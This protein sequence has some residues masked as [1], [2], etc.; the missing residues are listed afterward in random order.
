ML[1]PTYKS[2]QKLAARFRWGTLDKGFTG[3]DTIGEVEDY[4][5]DTKVPILGDYNADNIV[6]AADHTLWKSTLG[7]T[8]DL[9]ADGNKN[10]VI[11]T[12]DYSIWRDRLGQTSGGGAAAVVISDS[13]ASEAMLS[14][15]PVAESAPSAGAAAFQTLTLAVYDE[16]PATEL[17]NTSPVS[18][19]ATIVVSTIDSTSTSELVVIELLELQHSTSVGHAVDALAATGPSAGGAASVDLALLALVAGDVRS[20]TQNDDDPSADL[21]WLN[22]DGDQDAELD[23]ALAAAF[24]DEVDWRGVL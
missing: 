14:A 7:S 12:G 13:P 5:F 2:G 20:R 10:G 16:G 24:E 21:Q 3:H 18:A 1:L 15:P 6:D 8:T 19:S 22:E 11:D 23:L 17:G 4:R 9:R